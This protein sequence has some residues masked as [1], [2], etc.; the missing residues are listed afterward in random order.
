MP[1]LWYLLDR[2]SLRSFIVDFF[3][4]IINP[5]FVR[6]PRRTVRFAIGYYLHKDMIYD[7]KQIILIYLFTT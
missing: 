7:I 3:T 2:I 4:T 1:S 5:L 6:I